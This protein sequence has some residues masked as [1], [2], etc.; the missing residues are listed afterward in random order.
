MNST[1]NRD[2]FGAIRSDWHPNEHRTATSIAIGINRCNS[3][4]HCTTPRSYVRSAL[5]SFSDIMPEF[6]TTLLQAIHKIG[7]QV[8]PLNSRE[9]VDRRIGSHPPVSIGRR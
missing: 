4:L 8:T 1:L 3:S 6:D 7:H 9:N 5:R 2:G